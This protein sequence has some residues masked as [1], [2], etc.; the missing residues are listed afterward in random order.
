MCK[1][2]KIN[3]LSMFD[4]ASI[5]FLLGQ[6]VGRWGNFM[7]QEAFGCNTDLPWGM[8]STEVYNYLSAHKSSLA[9]EG[10]TVNPALP[11]HP[12]FLY[13]SLWCLIGFV[14]L[15]FLS[16]RRRYDGQILLW[17]IVWY[18]AGR[19]VIEGLRTDSLMIGPVRASQALA[20]V[21]VIAGIAAL[22]IFGKKYKNRPV[23]SDVVRIY[24][25]SAGKNGLSAAID[26]DKNDNASESTAEVATDDNSAKNQ[27]TPDGSDGEPAD[28]NK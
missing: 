4:L 10:I 22:I 26:D 7:N 16:R 23:G 9:A 1:I 13:E 11:V 15:H 17:Y 19:A 25:V 14:L 5:G 24:G 3:V 6:S 8:W 18:G 2:R 20:I 27:D 28:E 12:C 21:C